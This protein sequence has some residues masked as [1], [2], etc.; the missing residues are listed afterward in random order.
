MDKMNP[1]I[2]NRIVND[3][4]FA[5]R[6]KSFV[7]DV[8]VCDCI[9]EEEKEYLQIVAEEL[10]DYQIRTATEKEEIDYLTRLGLW[11]PKN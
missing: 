1:I 2:D 4:T 8:K 5:I 6:L 9:G 3:T 11:K 10:L 7:D